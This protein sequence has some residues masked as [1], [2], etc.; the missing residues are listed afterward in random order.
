MSKK[1]RHSKIKNTGVLF[2]VLTRQV[3]ADIIDGKESKAVSLIKKHFNKNST[4]GKELELYNILTTESYKSRSKAERLIDVVIKTRQRISNKIL[5][6]EK[7]NLIKAIKE[8]YDVKAL[9]STKMPNYKKL[10]SIYKL[11]LYETT[12]EDINPTEVV[13]SREYVVESL[14]VERSKPEAKSELLREYNSEDKDVKLLAYTLMVEKFNEKYSKLSQSQK[15]VLRKY[16]NNVSNTNSLTEFIDGEIINIKTTLKKLLPTVNDDI[17]S[18]KLR[19]V[20]E[21]VG[22]LTGSNEATENTVVTLMRYYELIK[23]LENVTGKVKN[24]HS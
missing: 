4:L 23:E 14:I 16:I 3:T 1:L 21:Q 11:F 5:R 13:D 20:T 24:L 6:S 19:E 2:E 12:G 18:I 15:N 7:Y 10:A 22:K 8:N 17:T 9:F